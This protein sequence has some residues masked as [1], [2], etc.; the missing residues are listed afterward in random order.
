MTNV[1]LG[2]YQKQKFNKLGAKEWDAALEA[3]MDF[4][5]NHGQ[6]HQ[7]TLMGLRFKAA[8]MASKVGGTWSTRL[9]KLEDYTNAKANKAAGMEPDAP[10]PVVPTKPVS[11]DSPPPIE[12]G[13]WGQMQDVVPGQWVLY[14]GDFKKV[15]HVSPDATWIQAVDSNNHAHVWQALPGKPVKIYQDEN[16]VPAPPTAP[17][18]QATQTPKAPGTPPKGIG[19]IIKISPSG[20][21]TSPSGHANHKN[22]DHTKVTNWVHGINTAYHPPHTWTAKEIDAGITL[23]LLS[24]WKG[25]GNND[26]KALGRIYAFVSKKAA[27]LGGTWQARKEHIEMQLKAMG[28]TPSWLESSVGAPPF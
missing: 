11:A 5:T 10:T 26:L 25:G 27:K 9:K 6:D 19:N 1:Y 18:V 13:N 15:T 21:A 28:V 17:K 2:Y 12:A 16:S 20:Q 22:Y 7:L 4:E 24:I 14:K 23:L 8:K 3:V